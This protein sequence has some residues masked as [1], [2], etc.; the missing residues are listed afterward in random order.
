MKA[1]LVLAIVTTLLTSFCSTGYAQG[2][3]ANWNQFRGPNGDGK[4]LA[5]NLPVDVRDTQ[6]L[7]WKTAILGRGF[8]SLAIWY[9]QLCL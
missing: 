5:K 6:H 2:G 8:S 7:L 3:E 1:S 9:Y 4:S